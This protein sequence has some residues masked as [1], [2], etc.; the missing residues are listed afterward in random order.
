MRDLLICIAHHSAPGRLNFLAQVL[1]EFRNQYKI[2]HDII[3]DT[4]AEG[5]TVEDG[6]DDNET[7]VFHPSLAHPFNLTWCHRKHMRARIDR[8]QWFAYF[9]DD[10]LLPFENFLHYMD[11]FALLW[12]KY[13]PSFLRVETLD[14]AEYAL[15]VTAR[16]QLKQIQIGDRTFTTLSQPYHACWCM[17]QA[18]LRESMTPE[19]DRVSESREV[20]ASFP[21]WELNKTPLVEL[22]GNQ[23]S[24]KC[25]AYHLPNNYCRAPESPHGKIRVEEIFS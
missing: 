7:V 23:I 9:E 18:A 3:I 5:W 20:A 19:F 24:K 16:Q 6:W 15:D 22:D 13:V 12:P 2:G 1:R 17:S 25:I 14:G 11:N 21:M 10:L 4:D 8:Y